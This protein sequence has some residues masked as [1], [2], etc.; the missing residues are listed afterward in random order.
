MNGVDEALAQAH[1]LLAPY[2]GIET[3]PEPNR[4][5][6][7]VSVD[8]LVAA[9]QALSAAEWGYLA[10]MTGLDHGPA[11]QT[12][13]V[14]YHFCAGAAGVTL[15]VT[16]ARE[17]ATVPSLTHVTPAT[18]LYEREVSE[19]LGVTFTGSPNRDRLY[20]A[21]DWPAEVYPLRKDAV[22]TPPGGGE[23]PGHDA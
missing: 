6:V 10:A 14:L 15:R 19:M 13:E 11:A 17:A 4:L 5:D 12:L 18:A 3:R 2:G 23:R 9:A 20:L 22:I 16:V 1:E 7:A 8:Q 21:E